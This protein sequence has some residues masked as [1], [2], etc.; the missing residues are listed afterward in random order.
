MK[1]NVSCDVADCKH[2][3]NGYCRKTVTGL[4]IK[5]GSCANCVTNMG[6]LR[7]KWKW[8][9]GKELSPR[10]IREGARG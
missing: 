7:E 1:L 5:N 2:N 10:R 3:E 9:P 6:F 8:E 4:T